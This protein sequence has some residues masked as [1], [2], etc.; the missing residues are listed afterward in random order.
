LSIKDD[1]TGFDPSTQSSGIGFTSMRE[2][3]RMVGGGLLVK[4]SPGEGTEVTAQ[5]GISQP[6]ASAVGA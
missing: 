1:G 2:R 6:K 5:V 3:L 4:S